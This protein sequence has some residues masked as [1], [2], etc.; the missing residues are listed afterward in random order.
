[1][2]Q[3]QYFLGADVHLCKTDFHWI[4]LDLARDR[5]LAIHNR[6]FEPF[7]PH[8]HG[9]QQCATPAAQSASDSEPTPQLAV[10]LLSEGL[11]TPDGKSGKVFA[12]IDVKAPGEALDRAI[13]SPFPSLIRGPTFFLASIKADHLLRRSHIADIVRSVRA[14]KQGPR[15]LGR[16]FDIVKASRLIRQFNVLRPFYP[17]D[18][19][20][21]FES[22][23]LIEFLALHRLFPDWVFGVTSDP[24]MAHCWVQDG[25]RLLNESVERASAYVPIMTI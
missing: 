24:F 4:L 11:V 23:A 22:L 18:Y 17:R 3:P 9:W 5:Y 2:I 20:C 25:D 13:H 19:L 8:L 6:D 16:G 10:Q 15:Q 12:A 21:L 7:G 1:V 14:R